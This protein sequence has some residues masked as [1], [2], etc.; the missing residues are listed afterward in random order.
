MFGCWLKGTSKTGISDLATEPA[1]TKP[2]SL[3]GSWGF[4]L[5]TI[6]NGA[7]VNICVQVSVWTN[8]LI[9]LEYPPKTG[10]AEER[11]VDLCFAF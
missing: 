2:S 3:D 4:F 8:F 11:T 5:L 7:A 6:T 9:S 10:N 1:P